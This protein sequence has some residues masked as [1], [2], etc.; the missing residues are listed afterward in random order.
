MSA[1]Q[2][3]QSSEPTHIGD[4]PGDDVIT[5]GVVLALNYPSENEGEMCGASSPSGL[6]TMEAV[7][8]AISNTR[9][10]HKEAGVK[11]GN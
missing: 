11:I 1:Q 6:A 5:F 3:S 7:A 2:C 4:P 10:M 9:G 8:W